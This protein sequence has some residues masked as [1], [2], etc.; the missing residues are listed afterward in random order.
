MNDSF[1]PLSG[2][3]VYN[4]LVDNKFKLSNS[5]CICLLK[6]S[7]LKI[8]DLYMTSTGELVFEIEK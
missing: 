7:K 5:D 8:K 4:Y 2:K 3:D 6:D 1:K